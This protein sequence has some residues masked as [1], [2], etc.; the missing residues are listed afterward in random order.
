MY[1]HAA[2]FEIL[3][4]IFYI[5]TQLK[6]MAGRLIFEF[7]QWIPWMSSGIPY[8]IYLGMP[9]YTSVLNLRSGFL[10]IFIKCIHAHIMIYHLRKPRIL[11]FG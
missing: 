6:A 11:I 9:I 2:I 8:I 5:F 3:R 7:Y 4:Y 1:A 10:F